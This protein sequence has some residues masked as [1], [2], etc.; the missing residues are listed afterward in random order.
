MTEP[1]DYKSAYEAAMRIVRSVFA[2]KY[3]DTYFICGEAGQKDLNNMP[4]QILVCPA[5]GC[6]FSYIYQKTEKTTGPEW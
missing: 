3:P 1:V 2:E 5:Y 6:D 4:D